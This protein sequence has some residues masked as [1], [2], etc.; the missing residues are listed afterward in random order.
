MRDF[1]H[2][3]ARPSSSAVLPRD[4]SRRSAGRFP[5]RSMNKTQPVLSPN[6]MLRRK[7]WSRLAKSLHIP[8]RDDFIGEACGIILSVGD[9]F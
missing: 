4:R 6:L 3:A 2:R 5:S 9:L 1:A 7:G 8:L